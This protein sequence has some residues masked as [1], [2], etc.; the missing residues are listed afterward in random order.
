MGINW[1]Y[2]FLA[3]IGKQIIAWS[4]QI[5]ACRNRE[6]EVKNISLIKNPFF[7]SEEFITN[8]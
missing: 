6:A 7:F 1:I 8:K 3:R 4:A 2:T 5:I